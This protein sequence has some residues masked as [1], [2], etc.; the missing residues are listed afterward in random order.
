MAGG[1]TSLTILG[2]LTVIEP[3]VGVG[4]APLR[5]FRN[6]LAQSVSHNATIAISQT[7]ILNAAMAQNQTLCT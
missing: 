6:C 1:C 4:Q 3:C 5:R 2:E 7:I